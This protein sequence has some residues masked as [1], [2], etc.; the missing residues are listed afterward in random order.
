MAQFVKCSF[1]TSSHPKSRG[2]PDE[3]EEQ[4]Y[5]WGKSCCSGFQSSPFPHL[6]SSSCMVLECDPCPDVTETVL[7]KK[8]HG[9]MQNPWISLEVPL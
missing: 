7:G 1:K 9:L 2:H 5:L 8:Y 4:R 3:M 6:S